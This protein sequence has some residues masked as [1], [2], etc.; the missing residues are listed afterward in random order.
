MP[1]LEISRAAN[2]FD[3]AGHLVDP[4]TRAQ[5]DAYLAE[6]GKWLSIEP[7]TASAARR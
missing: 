6:L 2:Q 5:L 4:D 1:P 7:A 3:A